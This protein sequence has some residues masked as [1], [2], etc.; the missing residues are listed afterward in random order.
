MVDVD[1]SNVADAS[2][3]YAVIPADTYRLEAIEVD[4][5]K[6][7]RDGYEMWRVK[8]RVFMGD[9]K[10]SCLYDNLVFSK[11]AMP[12]VKMCFKAA[13]IDLD[14]KTFTTRMLL[15]KC[16]N[17]KVE[18]DTYQ[19]KQQN[20]I[21]FGGYSVEQQMP[22]VQAPVEIPEHVPSPLGDDD[23]DLPF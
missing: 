13:G 1:F 10:D 23:E 2:G 19:D 17:A 14:A 5:S 20:K 7:T 3:D 18:I 12:K 21:G 9:F 8:W 15:H 4:D 16:V 22:D 11:K 6:D